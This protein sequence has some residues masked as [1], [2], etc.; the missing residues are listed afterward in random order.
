[1]RTSVPKWCSD[2]LRELVEALRRE[3]G[4]ESEGFQFCAFCRPQD[5]LK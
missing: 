4:P 1:L 5:D 2:D 3:Y